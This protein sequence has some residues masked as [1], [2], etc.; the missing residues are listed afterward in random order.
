M[1]KRLGIKC[2]WSEFC[3]VLR[4][5]VIE[6][7]GKVWLFSLSLSVKRKFKL[8]PFFFFLVDPAFCHFTW[9]RSRRYQTTTTDNSSLPLSGLNLIRPI[10]HSYSS[11]HTSTYR[12]PYN[13]FLSFFLS[14]FYFNPVLTKRENIVSFFFHRGK[15]IPLL[16]MN[17]NLNAHQFLQSLTVG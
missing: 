1:L 10:L 9:K 12:S 4:F 6:T 15:Y 11:N 14:F 3:N 5:V 8:I 13:W 16:N 2:E 7:V 17:E